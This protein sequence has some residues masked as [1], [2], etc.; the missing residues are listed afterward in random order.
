MAFVLKVSLEPLPTPYLAIVKRRSGEGH[1]TYFLVIYEKM[2]GDASVG[3][4]RNT[5][6]KYYYDYNILNVV[7]IFLRDDGR[8]Y[9]ATYLPFE[10]KVIYFPFTTYLQTELY[11]DKVKDFKGSVIKVSL[12]NEE[13]RAIFNPKEIVGADAFMAQLLAKRLNATLIVKKPG[14]NDDYGNPTNNRNRA[15]GSLGQVVREEVDISLNARFMRLDLFYNNNLAEPTMHLGRDDMCVLIPKAANNPMIVN[16]YRSLDLTVW[17]LLL[18]IIFP[19]AGIFHYI[20]TSSRICGDRDPYRRP[21]L[22]DLLRSFFNQNLTHLPRTT[23]LRYLIIFWIIYCFLVTNILQS[24]LTS[25]LT[26]KG[27]G[28]DIHSIA[29]LSL[30]S[31]KVIAAADYA[32]LV[33]T[34]FNQN[35]SNQKR[36]TNKLLPMPWAKYNQFIGN[37][38]VEY[39]Y[40]NKYHMTKYYESVK[41]AN[42]RPIYNAMKECLVP[43]LACYIVPFGSP[44]LGRINDIIA[45]TNQAGIFM[46]WDRTMNEKPKRVVQQHQNMK[47]KQSALTFDQL[48][49]FFLFWIGGLALSGCVFLGEILL[50]RKPK[51]A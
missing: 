19:F 2:L 33:T 48:Y 8:F 40:L 34:Y 10:H 44:F 15:T 39:A 14:D 26:V 51:V 42:G 49:V 30:S 25:S 38:N 9:I 46:I 24:C 45:W 32:N 3:V 23:Y 20:A 21:I 31:Y 27:N 50:F 47:G 43:F 12:F 28:K 5:L 37:N 6:M 16:L 7:I 41:I 1:R 35:G 4:I 17:L 22:L 36:L 11:P 18:L 29:D 13:V